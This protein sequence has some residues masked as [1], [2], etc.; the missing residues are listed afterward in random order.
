MEVGNNDFVIL[1]TIIRHNNNRNYNYLSMNR[2]KNNSNNIKIILIVSLNG[3]L[4][5]RL[6]VYLKNYICIFLTLV[7]FSCAMKVRL[8]GTSPTSAPSCG[9]LTH[10]GRVLPYRRI[11]AWQTQHIRSISWATRDS[12]RARG[13]TYNEITKDRVTLISISFFAVD[14]N[15]EPCGLLRNGAFTRIA[16]NKGETRC[17]Y[18]R[19]ISD[20]CVLDILRSNSRVARDVMCTYI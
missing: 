4:E 6:F 1:I 11:S 2:Y 17:S 14:Y 9:I 13:N 20:I 15:N 3:F 7:Y 5:H 12:S 18:N 8:S 19:T 10:L 16:R